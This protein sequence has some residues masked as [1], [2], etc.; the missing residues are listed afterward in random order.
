MT[1]SSPNDAP[2]DHL[3][4]GVRVVE[5]GDEVP[6]MPGGCWPGWART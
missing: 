6:P 4:D 2:T 5:I 3:L 1:D